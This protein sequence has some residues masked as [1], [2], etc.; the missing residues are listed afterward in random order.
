MRYPFNRKM[1]IKI[2]QKLLSFLWS[3][4]MRHGNELSHRLVLKHWV[5]Q[6]ILRINAHVPWPVH[7]TSNVTA[8]DKIYRGTRAP[9]LGI[10]CHIDGRN[11]ICFGRN[12][13]IGP[14][15]SVISMNHDT[16]NF[17]RYSEAPPIVIHKNCWLGA[18]CIILPGVELGEHTVVAAGAVVA[19]SFTEGNV[20]LAGVPAKVVKLLKPYS[21]EGDTN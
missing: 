3:D 15:V 11:G 18:N 7:P 17:R 1:L 2:T 4:Y 13:W 21:T 16:E 8:P 20:L 19:K 14:R 9:G 6:K 5:L 10:C 12:V